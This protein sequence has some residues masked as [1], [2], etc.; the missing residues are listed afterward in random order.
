MPLRSAR[1]ELDGVFGRRCG[2]EAAAAL[3]VEVLLAAVPGRES[4]RPGVVVSM[5]S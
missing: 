5:L 3:L 2:V 1:R 4:G